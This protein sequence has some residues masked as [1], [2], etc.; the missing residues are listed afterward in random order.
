MKRYLVTTA[1]ENLGHLN[2]FRI[3]SLKVSDEKIEFITDG[4]SLSGMEKLFSLEYQDLYKTKCKSFFKKH[5]ITLLGTL[6]IVTSLV[7]QSFSVRRIVF[8]DPETY[9][10]EVLGYLDGRFRRFGP[11]AFLEGNLS[12]INK[13]L[14]SEFY[15]YEWIGLRRKGATLYIDIR[16][17]KNAPQ[18]EDKTPGSLYAK[19]SGI[20][21]MY[22]AERGVVLA[23]EE[24]YV[25]KGALLISGEIAGYD[26]R[27]EL[28]RAKGWVLA[29]VLKYHDYK[30]LKEKK[31]T[32][33]T[34]K[35]EIKKQYYLF[36][37][38]LNKPSTSFPDFESVLGE[39]RSVGFLKIQEI[40]FFE[41]KTVK[42]V[43]SPEEAVRHAKSEVIKEFRKN[44]VSPH[45]KII[46]NKLVKIEF[47]GTYYRIRLIVKAERNIAE[48]VPFSN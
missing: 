39:A 46:Y 3:K 7:I 22:H 21:K 41:T 19:D 25:E 10:P 8:S 16:E 36:S 4:R 1:K 14:R 11:F 43:Y 48:F 44:K 40:Y 37:R 38:P 17:I 28:V 30:I 18:E 29:E 45:E 34:G 23:Q 20:V 12:E 27:T 15:H 2:H 47:D 26:N 32:I 42:T 31:E 9:N 5:L 6:I 24:V 35:V 33:R 13:D